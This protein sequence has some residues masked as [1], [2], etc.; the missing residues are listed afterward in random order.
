MFNGCINLTSLNLSG[1]DTKNVT[2]MG[3]MFSGCNKL[4]S[5]DVSGFDTSKVDNMSY[6]FNGCNNLTSLDL[7]GFD[8]SKV[9]DMNSMFAGC[10]NLEQLKGNFVLNNVTCTNMFK[11]CFKAPDLSE[12]KMSGTVKRVDYMFGSFGF[13]NTPLATSLDLSDIALADGCMIPQYTFFRC[14]VTDIYPFTNINA[15]CHL[16]EVNLSQEVILRFINNLVE[17][18][19]SPTLTLGA[20]NLAKLTEDQIAIAVNKGWTVA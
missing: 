18:T 4:T 19:T 14:T 15:N 8:T 7:S 2:N 16:G 9:T 1:F 10:S 3:S 12:F 11:E 13:N 6:M 17:V 5:L 20:T